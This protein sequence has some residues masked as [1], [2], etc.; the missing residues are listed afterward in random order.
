MKAFY[1]GLGQRRDGLLGSRIRQNSGVLEGPPE[2]WR[3]QL[4]LPAPLVSVYSVSNPSRRWDLGVKLK[5]IKIAPWRLLREYQSPK[6]GFNYE[7]IWLTQ[8][9]KQRKRPRKT[10]P[11]ERL[12]WDSLGSLN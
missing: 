12:D 2:V 1:W 9:K 4:H 7:A 8:R 3:H 11:C 5:L 6:S 10:A